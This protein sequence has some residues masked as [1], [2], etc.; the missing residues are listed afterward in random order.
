MAIINVNVSL[1]SA[2]RRRNMADIDHLLP[3][4][5]MSGSSQLKD[6]AERGDRSSTESACQLSPNVSMASF[7]DTV[8]G[9]MHERILYCSTVRIVFDCRKSVGW[10]S[11]F[12]SVRGE[13]RVNRTWLNL[14]CR[15][16]QRED[17]KMSRRHRCERR[18]CILRRET[19]CFSSR[20]ESCREYRRSTEDCRCTD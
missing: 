13:R 4:S 10:K 16:T 6:K 18:T 8:V 7:V 20:N 2:L 19:V 1:P 15:D 14:L 3:K 9:Q 17:R 11:S 5:S 12:S